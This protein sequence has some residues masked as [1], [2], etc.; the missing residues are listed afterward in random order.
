MAWLPWN[1]GNFHRVTNK[2]TITLR[3]VQTCCLF[4]RQRTPGKGPLLAGNIIA[5]VA[6]KLNPRLYQGLVCLQARHVNDCNILHND[7]R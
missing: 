6:D 2:L 5:C 1:F 3:K 4:S 7:S